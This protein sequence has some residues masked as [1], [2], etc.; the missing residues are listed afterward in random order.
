[1]QVKTPKMWPIRLWNQFIANLWTCIYDAY[2]VNH[3]GSAG[4]L[5]A[6]SIKESSRQKNMTEICWNL[7]YS[8]TLQVFPTQ[9]TLHT[10]LQARFDN[11]MIFFGS[12]IGE[13]KEE[14]RNNYTQTS[15]L[16]IKGRNESLKKGRVWSRRRRRWIRIEL[17]TI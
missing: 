1:M 10:V 8:I 11:E 16:A 17:N 12:N 2:D 6:D 4:K 3:I 14:V 5:E 7:W 15:V 9:T 13:E